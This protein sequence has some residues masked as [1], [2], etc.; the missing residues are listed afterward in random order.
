MDQAEEKKLRAT[1]KW[2]L[3]ENRH[4][5]IKK[6]MDASGLSRP[7][8]SRFANGGTVEPESLQ[9]LDAAINAL[10]WGPPQPEAFDE[11][12]DAL[13]DSI[14]ILK[15]TILLI[16]DPDKGRGKKARLILKFLQIIES[17]FAA[18]LSEIGRDE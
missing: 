9:S 5:G 1:I 7:T 13:S 16:E 18:E 3:N 2:F 15:D 12:N 14:A 6:L 11:T 8:V 17:E 4:G 10:E